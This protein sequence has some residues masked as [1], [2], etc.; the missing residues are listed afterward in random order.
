MSHATAAACPLSIVALLGLN[1]KDTAEGLGETADI[2]PFDT[3]VNLRP[4]R[5]G[6]LLSAC[7]QVPHGDVCPSLRP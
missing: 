1:T 3:I 7:Q 5:R 4:R 6:P 2:E